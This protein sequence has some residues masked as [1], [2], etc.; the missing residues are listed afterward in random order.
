MTNRQSLLALGAVAFALWLATRDVRTAYAGIDIMPDAGGNFPPIYPDVTG[1]GAVD[2]IATWPGWLGTPPY[3][4]Y[5][6][7]QPSA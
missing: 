1:S 5:P 7:L 6:G 2:S 4:P 3:A